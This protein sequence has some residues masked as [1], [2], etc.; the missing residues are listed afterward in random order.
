MLNTLNSLQHAGCILSSFHHLYIE[1]NEKCKK[2][3]EVGLIE[4]LPF[5]L[6]F[7]YLS[8]IGCKVTIEQG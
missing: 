5:I 7:S 1:K 3:A 6:S 4:L 2:N 8:F